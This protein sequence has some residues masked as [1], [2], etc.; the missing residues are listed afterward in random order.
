MSN[1]KVPAFLIF[2]KRDFCFIRTKKYLQ[3]G[4]VTKFKNLILSPI[5]TV[6]FSAQK[7]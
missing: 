7:V 4:N 2:N 5:H 3:V 1:E 6:Y